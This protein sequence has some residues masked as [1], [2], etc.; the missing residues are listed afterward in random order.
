MPI[1]AMPTHSDDVPPPKPHRGNIPVNQMIRA[2]AI[3]AMLA[4]PFPVLAA[5]LDAVLYKE[6]Q[7][8]CCQNYADYLAE[9]GFSVEVKPTEDL[10]AITHDAGVPDDIA[11]CH[12]MLVDGYVVGGHVPVDIVKKLLSERPAI[13]GI[14]LPGMPMGSPGMGGEKTGPLTVYAFTKGGNAPTVYAEE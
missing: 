2:G 3:A 10:A 6:P 4:M 12:T 1:P 11:G 13:T 7:C 9:N 14:T 5:S 8:G